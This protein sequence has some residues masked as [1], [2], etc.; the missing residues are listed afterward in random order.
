MYRGVFLILY[1]ICS[2]RLSKFPVVIQNRIFCF[3]SSAV[4]EYDYHK[5][6]GLDLG[7]AIHVCMYSFHIHLVN[8]VIECG[9]LPIPFIFIILWDIQFNVSYVH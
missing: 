7:A 1:L 6:W 4:H 8:M 9:L 5:F 2:G 3:L